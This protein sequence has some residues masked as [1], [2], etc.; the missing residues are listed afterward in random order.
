MFSNVFETAD[1]RI[2]NALKEIGFC[3]NVM[4][5][6]IQEKQKVINRLLVAREKIMFPPLSINLG[7]MGQWTLST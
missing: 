4:D 5:N 6:I 2:S 7:H 1:I 3:G